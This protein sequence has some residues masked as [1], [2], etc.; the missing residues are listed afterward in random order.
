MGWPQPSTFPVRQDLEGQIGTIGGRFRG[1]LI[2]VEVTSAETWVV[3][4]SLGRR[5]RMH[6]SFPLALGRCELGLEVFSAPRGPTRFTGAARSGSGV[7]S[8]KPAEHFVGEREDVFD[9]DL[10][11]ALAER[12][13]QLR[14]D[15]YG[16]QTTIET[17][18]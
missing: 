5:L 12:A 15:M 8:V 2:E 3:E 17:R 6:R 18:G 11:V 16:R 4:I 10:L 9:L 13:D 14:G 7:T 1:S